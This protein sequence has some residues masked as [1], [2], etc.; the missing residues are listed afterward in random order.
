MRKRQQKVDIVVTWNSGT[1][2]AAN[3]GEPDPELIRE[4]AAELGRMAARYAMAQAR[5]R[6][7]NAKKECVADLGKQPTDVVK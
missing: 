2:A 4:L 7:L 1:S 6:A 5:E 3:P